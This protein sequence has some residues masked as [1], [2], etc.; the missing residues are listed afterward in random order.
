MPF[1]KFTVELSLPVSDVAARIRSMTRAPRGFGE[2][3]RTAFREAQPSAPPFIG[4]VHE[5]S[6]RVRRDIRYRNSFLPRVWRRTAAIPGGSQLRVT[7]FLRA[8]RAAER[9]RPGGNTVGLVS[10]R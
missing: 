8:P 10:H 5:A 7:M 2:A 9:M 6:F 1:Y 4:Q 3:R